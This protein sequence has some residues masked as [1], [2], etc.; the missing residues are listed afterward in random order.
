MKKVPTLFK[1]ALKVAQ[2]AAMEAG[3]FALEE[4]TKIH[5]YKQKPMTTD[6][7]SAVDIESEKRIV[8]IIKQ[9]FPG[10]TL[11]TEERLLPKK[12]KDYSW[13][14]DP[15]D[16]S[17]S[18]RFNLPY[19]GVCLALIYKGEP[20][21]A[22]SYFPQTRSLYSAVR[23]QGAF[24][25]YKK[26]NVSETRKL[27]DGII[28]IDYGYRNERREGVK[29]VTFKLSDEVQYLVTYA[30]TAAAIALVAEGKLISY[31]HHNGRRFDHAAGALLVKEAGGEVT[32]TKGKKINWKNTDPINFV[33]SNGKVH[34]ELIRLLKV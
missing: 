8:K 21:V 10:H 18:Y 4:F 17:V 23:D 24:K 11:F 30:C 22:V 5:E 3:D 19:W 9:N 28:G 15:L 13:W 12:A 20:V 34:E 33:C 1:K 27:V 25:N 29:D 6:I 31:I 16:G 7:V 26:I 2:L 14:I 32:N